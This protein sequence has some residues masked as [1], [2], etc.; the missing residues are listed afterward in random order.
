MAKF[1]VG[2]RVRIL[3]SENW[4]ELAGKEGVVVG[5]NPDVS[6]DP[7][8]EVEVN[9]ICWGGRRAPYRG[10]FGANVFSPKREWLEPILPE[11]STP[12]EFTFQQ[13]MDSLQEA[14]A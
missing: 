3:H 12:S 14:T 4:P 2:Q 1:F 13:L 10:R 9:P 11:G 6:F 7:R 8:C 5:L